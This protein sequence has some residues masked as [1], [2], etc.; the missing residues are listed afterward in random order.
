MSRT[1][2]TNIN[3]SNNQ[4][5][6]VVIS[7]SAPGSPIAGNLWY[8]SDHLKLR[9]ASATKTVANQDDTFFIGTTEISLSQGSNTI[10][11][12]AGVS[13][14]GNAG[15]VSGTV[16]VANGGTGTTTG[17]ITGTGALTFTAGGT[18]TNVNLAPNGTGTVDVASKRITNVATPSSSTDAANK[19]YVDNAVVGID[20]KQSVQLATTTNVSLSTSSTPLTLDGIS[21]AAGDRILVKDQSTGS[22]NGIYLVS[23]SAPNYSYARSSD[24]DTDAELTSSFAVFGEKGNTQADSGWT[25]TNDGTITVGTTA[26]TFT[27]F[28][29]LGQV[30]AGIGL[31]K[32]GNTLDID[33]V[34]IANGGTNAAT[35]GEA[36]TNLGAIGVYSTT[37][38]SITPS[39]GVAYWRIP[40]ATHSLE[41]SL[42]KLTVQMFRVDSTTGTNYLVEPDIEIINNASTA[43]SNYGFTLTLN[44][45]LLSWNAASTV[46][47]GTYR[48]VITG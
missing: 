4:L 1:F 31:T 39:G 25:L 9:G 37:N 12:L 18:N 17:S 14:S 5:I 33:T 23:Y 29:G 34:P 38:S 28:T 6:N 42:Q 44:D 27:Q 7:N 40:A 41:S 22:Q 43:T 45:V 26:L 30:T 8:A 11:S 35:A 32:T 10:T 21:V 13:I 2:L 19:A 47:S 16:A 20:W 24:A 48:V 36:R 3:L 46:T 15:N